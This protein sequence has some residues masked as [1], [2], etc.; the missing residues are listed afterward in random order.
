MKARLRAVL[1]NGVAPATVKNWDNFDEGSH[2]E[3]ASEELIEPGDLVQPVV[4]LTIYGDP[5]TIDDIPV[6]RQVGKKRGQVHPDL[7]PH[8]DVTNGPSMDGDSFGIYIESRRINGDRVKYVGPHWTNKHAA[9][10]HEMRHIFVFRGRH[11]I[12]D[13]EDVKK[14]Q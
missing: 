4:D 9:K 1:R 13:M 12:C 11:V 8:L 14:V 2:N 7:V 10:L 3:Q 5:C 6:A